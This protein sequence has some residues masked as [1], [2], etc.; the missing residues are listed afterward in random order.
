MKFQAVE[1]AFARLAP[2]RQA[3][4]RAMTLA[5]LVETNGDVRRISELQG[6]GTFT[7]QLENG[8]DDV[9]QVFAS[10]VEGDDEAIVG[11]RRF[12]NFVER[13]LGGN[14]LSLFQDR[15]SDRFGVREFWFPTFRV[16]SVFE[17][18]GTEDL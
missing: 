12:D 11:Q 14:V 6:V 15:T 2:C 10:A 7:Q 16:V 17:F 9:G 18:Q 8:R 13:F 5:I 4:H 3:S 1:P